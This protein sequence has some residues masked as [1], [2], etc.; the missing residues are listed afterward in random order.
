MKKYNLSKKT[1]YR[2]NLA[3][4][5]D[6]RNINASYLAMATGISKATIYRIRSNKYNKT[7]NR[8]VNTIC[9]AFGISLDEFMIRVDFNQMIKEKMCEVSFAP[10]NVLKLHNI[11]LETTG[12]K[13][14]IEPYN[15]GYSININSKWQRKNNF[16]GN[17]RLTIED[18]EIVFKVLDFD[19][20]SFDDYFFKSIILG[21]E[22][23]AKEIGIKYVIFSH[24]VLYNTYNLVYQPI[25][26]LLQNGYGYYNDF[27]QN[28]TLFD[29]NEVYERVLGK[30]DRIYGFTKFITYKQV[31]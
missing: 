27:L 25:K 18:N 5:M 14:K 21:F 4:L 1:V 23:Y 12:T 2:N 11:L 19:F 24:G 16:S 17:V 10:S 20:T 29:D 9:D 15:S 6:S 30:K 26:A 7:T 8:V 28:I 13:F 3:K 22:K 31:C